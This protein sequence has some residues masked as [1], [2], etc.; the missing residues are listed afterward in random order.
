MQVFYN[1]NLIKIRIPL[2]DCIAHE[3]IKIA[4]S[5]TWF[6]E[7]KTNKKNLIDKSN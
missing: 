7:V 3:E 2:Q 6:I 5:E 1:L 4:V